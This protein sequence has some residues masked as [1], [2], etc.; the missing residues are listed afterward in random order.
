MTASVPCCCN[1]RGSCWCT[2]LLY[3]R[4]VNVFSFFSTAPHL[5]HHTHTH[6]NTQTYVNTTR[7]HTQIVVA[8]AAI[9]FGTAL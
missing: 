1:A 6:T 5:Q 2:N 3:F 4:V 7:A 8:I 9:I